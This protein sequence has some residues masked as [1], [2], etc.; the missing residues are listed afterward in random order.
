VLE[1]VVDLMYNI[2][3]LDQATKTGWAHTCGASGV[4]DFKIRKDESSGMRL[5]RFRGKILEIM[6]SAGVDII[7][8][9]TPSVACGVKANIDGLKLGTKLQAVIEQIAVEYPA[10]EHVGFNSQEIKTHALQDEPKGT[11]RDKE[12]MVRV[13]KRKWPGLE[14]IDDNHADALWILDLA[15]ELYGG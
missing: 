12:S 3:A 13:A 7:A 15:T 1:S 9:E 10:I 8:F 2:L 14:I 4:W 6:N 11:K 5:I